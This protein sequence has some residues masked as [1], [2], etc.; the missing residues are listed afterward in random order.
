MDC[1]SGLQVLGMVPE[2]CMIGLI[3]F[4]TYVHVHELGFGLIP[5]VHV[6]KG[7]KEVTKDQLL[8]Q[9]GFFTKRPRPTTGVIAGVRDGLSQESVAR[10]L[11]PA[12]DC[13]FVLNSV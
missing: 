13:E 10:F 9:M 3:T 8:E 1:L 11:L 7:T 4:G 2:N 12:S 6:F 5:K